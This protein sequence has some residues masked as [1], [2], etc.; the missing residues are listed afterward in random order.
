[1]KKK[2]ITLISA[3]CVV[4]VVTVTSAIIFNRPDNDDGTSGTTVSDLLASW[5][6]I[7]DGPQADD[8]TDVENI[9][10]TNNSANY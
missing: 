2:V 5:S 9:S 7:T 6:S 10:Y 1:M 3:V 8:I 4:A